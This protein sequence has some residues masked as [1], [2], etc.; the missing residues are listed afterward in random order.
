MKWTIL[1]KE[2]IKSETITKK[3]ICA[4]I[5]AISIAN[6]NRI[7][8]FRKKIMLKYS[9]IK[10]VSLIAFFSVFARDH[11]YYWKKLLL[12]FFAIFHLNEDHWNKKNEIAGN[13]TTPKQHTPPTARN[14]QPNRILKN[15]HKCLGKNLNGMDNLD[16]EL[17]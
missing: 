9:E 16:L 8:I 1:L 10:I 17:N 5:C 7:I 12:I 13:K 11:W 6:S 14:T 3:N 4:N 2:K 15:Q